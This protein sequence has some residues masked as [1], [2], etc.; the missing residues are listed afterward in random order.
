MRLMIALA[1]LIGPALAPSAAQAANL[2]EKT[3]NGYRTSCVQRC[4]ENHDRA[5]CQRACGC[6]SSEM[7]RH[8]TQESYDK[9]ANTLKKNPK[10]AT[11]RHMVQQ[12]AAYCYQK[13][14][15]M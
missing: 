4:V 1:L 3:L 6:M 5:T 15:G 8:W 14:R 12:L 10:E 11:T 9:F 2:S 13:A 7:S